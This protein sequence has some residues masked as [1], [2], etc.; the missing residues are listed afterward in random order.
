VLSKIKGE[1]TA[2]PQEKGCSVLSGKEVK[3]CPE[4]GGRDRRFN[5]KNQKETVRATIDLI[6]IFI[7]RKY[8]GKYEKAC[9]PALWPPNVR[10]SESGFRL[11]SQNEKFSSS[12]DGGRVPGCCL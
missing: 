8:L 3:V 7:R 6:G 10:S 2:L 5:Q 9:S 4:R 1:G 12:S 11:S